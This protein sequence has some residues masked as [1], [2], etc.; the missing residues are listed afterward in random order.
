MLTTK[1][2]SFLD[3]NKHFLLHICLLTHAQVFFGKDCLIAACPDC[4]IS[5]KTTPNETAT[6]KYYFLTKLY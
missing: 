6:T 4:Y 3:V 2:F 5:G 1:Q